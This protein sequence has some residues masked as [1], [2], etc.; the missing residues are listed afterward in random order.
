MDR[1]SFAASE[2]CCYIAP[3]PS[4]ISP[5]EGHYRQRND[6]EE[7]EE[8]SVLPVFAREAESPEYDDS[9]LR[10]REWYRDGERH[11]CATD[12]TAA[13]WLPE[14]PFRLGGTVRY[15]AWTWYGRR[16][17]RVADEESGEKSR[18]PIGGKDGVKESRSW[19]CENC[20]LEN[21]RGCEP[22][23]LKQCCS[24]PPSSSPTKQRT[25]SSRAAKMD[26]LDRATRALENVV[27]VLGSKQRDDD[28]VRRRIEALE[29]RLETHFRQRD[30][31][32]PASSLPFGV[33]E[34]K[35]SFLTTSA[36]HHH[37]NGGVV[38]EAPVP[39]SFLETTAW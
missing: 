39:P 34:T 27:G 31:Q 1:R 15:E 7:T 12:Q 4:S 13:E 24:S 18:E 36:D 3:D 35:E 38:P 10:A 30:R 33:E 9:P 14:R 23:S 22:A 29:G 25:C 26:K 8:Y 19:T 16:V 2:N 6:A 11:T 21:R 5:F 37:A 32:P 28:L 20:G 17:L